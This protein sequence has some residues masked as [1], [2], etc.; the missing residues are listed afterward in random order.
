[1]ARPAVE[2]LAQGAKLHLVYRPELRNIEHLRRDLLEGKSVTIKGTYHLTEAQLFKGKAKRDPDDWDDDDEKIR[3]VVAKAVRGYF[4]F[5]P[6][7]LKVDVQVMVSVDAS[8]TWKWF[9]AEERVPVMRRLAEL[10]PNRIVIGGEARDAIA[11]AD[12]EKLVAQFPSP[13]E[14]RLYVQSRLGVVFRE[15][16]DATVD[17]S[18]RLER[19]VAKRVKAKPKDLI[20]PFRIEEIAKF[21]FLREQLLAMLA[22]DAGFPER[23]WQAQILDILRLLNPRY[24]AAFT[25]VMIKDSHTGRKR[26]LDIMLVDVNGNVDVIEIK[27]PFKAHLVT[28]AKYRDNHVPH[29]ELVGTVMQV[30]KYLFHM[31]RWGATGEEALTKRYAAKLPTDMKLRIV[32]PCGLIIMGRDDDLTLE[33]KGD[34]E[35]YRRQHKN[36][37]D[38]ITYDDLV[39]RL[40]RVL[41]QLRAGR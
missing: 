29:R 21:E 2:F 25:S 17:A 23:Q 32:N 3:F 33:Q 20:Q 16:T 10:R 34:F 22:N 27:K 15:L 36:V 19:Y 11:V 1:M 37:I 39:R 40:D 31:S 41:D 9:T 24:I 12:Y 6:S 38:V 8:P 18:A 30:E 7:V 28:P 14:M 4:V 35:M 26:Q 5:E 13:H